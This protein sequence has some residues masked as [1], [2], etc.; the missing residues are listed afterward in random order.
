M[1]G[2]WCLG[3]GVQGL[4]FGV[5]G[6]KFRGWGLNLN[7]RSLITDYC[8]FRLY[9][10]GT[11]SSKANLP[12]A[13]PF[14]VLCGAIFARPRSKIQTTETRVR[15]CGHTSPCRK[16][17]LSAGS[18]G[19]LSK[20]QKRLRF[21]GPNIIGLSATW[22]LVWGP[23]IFFNLNWWW[24]SNF[25]YCA[26][27]LDSLGHKDWIPGTILLFYPLSAET[28]EPLARF[29]RKLPK[30]ASYGEHEFF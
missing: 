7:L 8:K 14:R 17:V 29:V 23:M 25:G 3:Y 4:W 19:P 12:H 24:L 20:S 5:Q 1:F 28:L 27:T 22:P 10:L 2:V 16:D 30:A 11:L 13:I 6:L 15:R 26:M 21:Y 9:T 18:V